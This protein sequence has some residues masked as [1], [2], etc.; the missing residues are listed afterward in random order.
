M[1]FVSDIHMIYCDEKILNYRIKK[2]FVC[3]IIALKAGLI[4]L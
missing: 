3:R 1:K 4:K 2:E